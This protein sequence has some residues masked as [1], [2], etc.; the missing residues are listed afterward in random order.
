MVN[1][2]MPWQMTVAELKSV[3]DK[4]DPKA[5]VCLEVPA[6][7]IGHPEMAIFLNVKVTDKGPV[8]GL[9]PDLEEHA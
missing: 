4:A 1:E 2:P 8:V 5:V 9:R 7:G 3:L 6:G